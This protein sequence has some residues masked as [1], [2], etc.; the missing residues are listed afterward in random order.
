MT[1]DPKQT[2]DSCR[3][4]D[5]QNIASMRQSPFETLKIP[6]STNL[7]GHTTFHQ[8]NVGKTSDLLGNCPQSRQRML[9]GH[10]ESDGIVVPF[11]QRETPGVCVEPILGNAM[12]ISITKVESVAT[13]TFGSA[14]SGFAPLSLIL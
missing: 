12:D 5:P 11:K 10:T 14:A 7:V 8:Q 2:D 1:V 6:E 13:D 9:R 4:S 3:H